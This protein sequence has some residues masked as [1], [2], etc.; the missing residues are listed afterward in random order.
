MNAVLALTGEHE[1]CIHG[2]FLG[3]TFA[4]RGRGKDREETGSQAE[5]SFRV[6]RKGG[7]LV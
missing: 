1:H 7:Y 6:V 3:V 4:Q 2:L 5:D